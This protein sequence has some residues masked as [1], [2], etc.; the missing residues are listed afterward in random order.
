MDI[1]PYVEVRVTQ[2]LAAPPDR[3]FNAW[4]D[5]D[6]AG[7]WLFATASR[8]M[9]RVEIDARVGGSFRFEDRQVG[10]D[11]VQAGEYVEIVSP[12]RL[13]F[14]LDMENHSRVA[15]RVT[16]DIVPLERGCE[17]TLVHERVLPHNANRTEGRWTGMLY[18]LSGLLREK[19]HRQG[20]QG[21]EANNRVFAP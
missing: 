3:V 8:P 5:P 6:M 4:L 15:T 11:V 17:L 13:V 20:R 2:R 9:A 14:T 1:A 10:A 19:P 16:V 21:R 7:K 12:Q 18:G